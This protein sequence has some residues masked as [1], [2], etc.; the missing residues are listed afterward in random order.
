MA[1]PPIRSFRPRLIGSVMKLSRILLQLAATRAGRA[2]P[3]SARVAA[4][5]LPRSSV[6]RDPLSGPPPTRHQPAT[7]T[8]TTY[9]V[10]MLERRAALLSAVDLD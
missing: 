1:A 9:G 2:A 5:H 3:P 4:A 6:S 8:P 10:V 7:R